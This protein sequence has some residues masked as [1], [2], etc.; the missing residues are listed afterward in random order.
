VKDNSPG[1]FFAEASM[2]KS[3][4]SLVSLALCILLAGCG[5][6]ESLFPLYA[7]DDIYFDESLNG[8]WRM[9]D[10]P[11]QKSDNDLHL[12][13][14]GDKDG[15]VY[16]VVGRS[17]K[18]KDARIFME[19]R[20]VRIGKYEFID[21]E[22]PSDRRLEDEKIRDQVFPAVTGHIFGRV[23][24][25]RGG[26]KLSFLDDKWVSDEAKADRLKLL[27]VDTPDGI[28]LSAS[29]SDL[30]QFILEHAEDEKALSCVEYL[31]RED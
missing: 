15:R 27:H 31:V 28:L 21:F 9:I 19:A 22:T 4:L 13:F 5:P 25:E 14:K 3:A 2:R 11:E 17:E 1:L 30:K 12:L 16:V 18:N 24:R 29:T 6:Q 23:S 7:D 10:S 8:H 26:L 20:L